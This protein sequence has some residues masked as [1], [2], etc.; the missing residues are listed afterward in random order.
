MLRDPNEIITSLL[1]SRV[2]WKHDPRDTVRTALWHLR[3]RM[4]NVIIHTVNYRDMVNY[5]FATAKGVAEFLW[6]PEDDDTIAAMAG[7][8]DKN[9]RA[10]VK[11]VIFKDGEK[12]PVLQF[13]F[14][15]VTNVGG[16]VLRNKE[17][18]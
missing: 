7:V 10:K 12:E 16:V 9:P 4:D 15:E 5:P 2:V 8:V 18:Q 17:G 6:V 1:A 3:E 11:N 14:D 13:Q